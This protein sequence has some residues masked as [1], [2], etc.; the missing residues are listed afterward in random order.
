MK[1]KHLGILLI[2]I[3]IALFLT[4][5]SYT[6]ELRK[7][8][9]DQCQEACGAEMGGECPHSDGYP[10]Q[11]YIAFTITLI[12]G[13]VGGYLVFKSRK[14]EEKVSEREKEVQETMDDLE[15]DQRKIYKLIMDSEGA[16][17]Q[18]EIVEETDFSKA[19]VSRLLNKMEGKGVITR[20]KKGRTN[21]VI[22]KNK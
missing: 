18:S 1:E 17:Y 9:S 14:F 22:L 3:S 16:I 11:T 4:S 13:V 6:T 15:E 19:K 12:I 5:L 2:G 20:R 8:Q 21:L 10:L 7:I